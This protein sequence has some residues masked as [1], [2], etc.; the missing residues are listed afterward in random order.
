VARAQARQGHTKQEIGQAIL[1]A[2]YKVLPE[3]EGDPIGDINADELT[4]LFNQILDTPCVAIVDPKGGPINI[5]VPQPPDTVTSRQSLVEYLADFDPAEEAPDP[6]YHSH[7]SV[8]LL[9]GCGK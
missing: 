8:A 1:A 5:A 7:I 2:W 6:N 3:H 9:F 4:T